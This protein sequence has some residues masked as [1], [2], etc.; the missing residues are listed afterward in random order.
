MYQKQ[1]PRFLNQYIREIT[2]FSFEKREKYLKL[3]SSIFSK[4]LMIPSDNLG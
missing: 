1:A 4:R 2:T 3:E